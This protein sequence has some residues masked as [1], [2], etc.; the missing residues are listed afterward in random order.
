MKTPGII[1][2]KGF[3]EV[4]N[5]YDMLPNL[6]TVKAV[7]S[8]LV[9]LI[10][11]F[12]VSNEEKTVVFSMGFGTGALYKQLLR[13][14]LEEEQIRVL[15]MEYDPDLIKLAVEDFPGKYMEALTFRNVAAE[16]SSVIQKSL[17]QSLDVRENSVDILEARFVLHGV[18]FRKE[19]I[20]IIEGIYN[21]L[22]PRGIFVL[23]EIDNWIGTYIEK[24]LESL[25]KFYTELD[26]NIEKGTIVCKK[27]KA[28][29]F[30]IL[31]KSNHSDKDAVRALIK[32]NLEP[33]KIEAEKSGRIGWDEIVTDDI[34][35][36]V[37]GRKWYRSK[38]EWQEIVRAG[39]GEKVDI[40][41]ISTREIKNVHNDVVD[42]P[43]MLIATKVS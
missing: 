14:E 42:N 13:E 37:S 26:L 4:A 7:T 34:N 1:V 38:E 31:D 24:K 2:G 28:V 8:I 36:G 17:A 11:S 23:A 33:M 27:H 19:L 16:C 5:S 21:V 6:A 32:T 3:W 15:G 35:D 9:D 39:F 40:R 29:E 12:I 18:L 22:K 43:F 30:P 10:H 20:K 41:I 25:I